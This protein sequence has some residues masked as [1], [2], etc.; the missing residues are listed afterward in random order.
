[1][2]PSSIFLAVSLIFKMVPALDCIQK[3]GGFL[4][5]TCLSLSN[6]CM[7]PPSC[8]S[9]VSTIHIVCCMYVVDTAGTDL[10]AVVHDFTNLNA[11]P[12]CKTKQAGCHMLCRRGSFRSMCIIKYG[13]H[14]DI[15]D[16][17]M[18]LLFR[19]FCF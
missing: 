6:D 5:S 11:S 17:H 1:M 10:A 14:R 4:G 18:K 16:L 15:P 3:Q 2:T 13:R 19:L 12:T 9:V 8:H 7:H